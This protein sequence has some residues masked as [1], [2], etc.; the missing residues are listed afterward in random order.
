MEIWQHMDGSLKGWNDVNMD[1]NNASFNTNGTN[2]NI[3]HDLN[4]N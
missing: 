1:N 3:K 2:V 4:V